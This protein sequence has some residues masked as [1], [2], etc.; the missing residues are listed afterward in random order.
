MERISKQGFP[1]NQATGPEKLDYQ[2]SNTLADRTIGS[3]PLIGNIIMR[4]FK[5]AEFFHL[6]RNSNFL[7]RIVQVSGLRTGAFSA[8]IEP[9]GTYASG[10]TW[11]T[12]IRLKKQF[13]IGNR[14]G[15]DAFLDVFNLLSSNAQQSQ[16]NVTGAR[17]VKVDGTTY[18]Y[19]RFLSQ[20]SILPPRVARLGIRF[21]F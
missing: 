1:L 11:I 6:I 3:S 18:T 8:P 9:A 15:F 13:K 20:T 4:A 5:F 2:T 12:D 10:V 14:V 16:D 7:Y 17:T 19:Q 21:N